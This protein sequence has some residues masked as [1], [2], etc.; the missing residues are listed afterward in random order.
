MMHQSSSTATDA[1]TTQRGSA[2]E[3]LWNKKVRHP[4]EENDA[5]GGD[6][7]DDLKVHRVFVSCGTADDADDGVAVAVA[8]DSIL[9]N[10]WYN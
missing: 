5:S 1:R 9:L 10:G 8:A 4:W 6:D 7:D 2:L 3:R